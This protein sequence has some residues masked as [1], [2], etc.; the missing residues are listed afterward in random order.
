M[1]MALIRYLVITLPAAWAG[2]RIATAMGEPQLYGLIVGLLVVGLI[3]SGAF[4]LWLH[5]ALHAKERQFAAE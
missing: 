4:S 1:V 3:S 5:L 2:V